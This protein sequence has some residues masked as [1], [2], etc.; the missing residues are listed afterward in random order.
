MKHYYKIAI[1]FFIETNN[2]VQLAFA[3]K[4]IENYLKHF[5]QYEWYYNFNPEKVQPAIYDLLSEEQRYFYLLKFKIT[6]ENLR[7]YEIIKLINNYKFRKCEEIFSSRNYN[8]DLF[9]FSI[10]K[11]LESQKKEKEELESQSQ[12]IRNELKSLS[13]DKT[14]RNIIKNNISLYLSG[15]LLLFSMALIGLHYFIYSS[16]PLIFHQIQ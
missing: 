6:R 8:N 3:Y 2:S 7:K 13:N 5:N 10:D 9:T 12:K 4:E 11:V 1:K 15:F 14:E 16:D